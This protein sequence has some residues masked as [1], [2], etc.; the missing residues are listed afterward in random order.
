AAAALAALRRGTGVPP[1]RIDRTHA[2]LAFRREHYA[3]PVG[4]ECPPLWDPIAG[5]YR[6]A[7]GWIRLHTNYAHHRAAV[8]R[9]LGVAGARG[10]GADP[11]GRCRAD[12]RAQAG[13][14]AGG[15]AA[16]RR[17]LAAGRSPPQGRAV[18]ADPVLAFEHAAA[19]ALEL[20]PADLPL[21]G[22]RVLDLTR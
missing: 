3:A 5:D 11:G 8:L 14:A 9:V 13:V 4:W 21:S 2:A 22:V 10:P 6:A 12:A 20:G 7:D 15:C 17:P 18:A 1:V 19:P 16:A